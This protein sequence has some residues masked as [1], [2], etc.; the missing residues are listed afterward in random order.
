MFSIMTC[1]CPLVRLGLAFESATMVHFSG[2]PRGSTGWVGM[3]VYAMTTNYQFGDVWFLYR[4][5]IYSLQILLSR[6][7]A[8]P[9]RTVKQEREEI[10]PN[11]VR[12][13]DLISVYACYREF[14]ADQQP[15][16]VY[17]FRVHGYKRFTSIGQAPRGE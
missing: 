9:G 5:E 4:D 12:R 7:Q 6:T 3:G 14:V 1:G 11:H 8:G 16:P 2:K 15:H 17:T 10:S 13:I